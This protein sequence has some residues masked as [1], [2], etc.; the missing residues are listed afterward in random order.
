M[1]NVDGTR[2]SAS[3]ITHAAELIVEFQGHREKIT[4]EVTDL[5]KNSFILGFSWL[6]CHNPDIDWTKGTVKMTHCPRHCHMLQPKSAFLASLEKEEYDIQYQVHEMIHA[7]EV[8]QEKPKKRLL[9][10]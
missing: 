4:A 8:Q 5:G 10:S 3:S 6:K 1:Y 7:L 2:N 9:R